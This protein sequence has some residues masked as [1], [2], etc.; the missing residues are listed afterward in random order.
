MIFNLENFLERK[1]KIMSVQLQKITSY[2]DRKMIVEVDCALIT[3]SSG[4]LFKSMLLKY[5]SNKNIP[6]L[7][8]TFK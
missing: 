6:T 2:L 7:A 4:G 3:V 8:N 1:K 5:Y